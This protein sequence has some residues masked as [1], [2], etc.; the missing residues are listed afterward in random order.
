MCAA[1]SHH[2]STD[3]FAMPRPRVSRDKL[4]TAGEN[5]ERGRIEKGEKTR[6]GPRSW[7]TDEFVLVRLRRELNIPLAWP[8][9]PLSSSWYPKAGNSGNLQP[10]YRPR[11]VLPCFSRPGTQ[12]VHPLSYIHR[13]NDRTLQGLTYDVN[14]S[15]INIKICGSHVCNA[16]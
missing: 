15:S 13:R 9:L 8:P 5:H 16:Y 11:W 12:R 4:S 2:R 14:I 10:V 1:E 6:C 7:L 3:I